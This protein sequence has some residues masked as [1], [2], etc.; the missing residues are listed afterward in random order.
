MVIPGNTQLH[1]LRFSEQLK[2][3]ISI[4][5]I[6]KRNLNGPFILTL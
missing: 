3:R 5:L 6:R 2:L 1:I 4:N